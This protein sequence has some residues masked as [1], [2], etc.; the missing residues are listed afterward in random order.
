MIRRYETE[1]RNMERMSRYGCAIVLLMTA[2]CSVPVVS[3]RDQDVVDAAPLDGVTN[4]EGGV[5]SPGSPTNP[6][7]RPKGENFSLPIV[8]LLGYADVR[9]KKLRRCVMCQGNSGELVITRNGF[10]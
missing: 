8:L 7:P 2:A 10:S 4:R 6:P 5:K 3:D 1:T 9:F